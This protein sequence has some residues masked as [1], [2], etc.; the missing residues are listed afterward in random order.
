MAKKKGQPKLNVE[1]KIYGPGV[2]QEVRASQTG[3]PMVVIHFPDGATRTLLAAPE[4]WLTLPDLDAIPTKKAKRVPDEAEP[5][6]A[7]ELAA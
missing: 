4:Y 1:H 2:L 5:L 3:N 7:D 6:V